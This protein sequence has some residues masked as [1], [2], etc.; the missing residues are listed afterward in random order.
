[1]ICYDVFMVEIKKEEAVALA[2]AIN[3]I[4]PLTAIVTVGEDGSR[5]VEAV[6][7]DP[8]ISGSMAKWTTRSATEMLTAEQVV[9]H[10]QSEIAAAGKKTRRAIRAERSHS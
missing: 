4:R 7:R 1:M 3:A 2:K 5:A 9:A 10:L 8:W 6:I